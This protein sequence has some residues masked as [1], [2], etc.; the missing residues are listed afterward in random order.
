MSYRSGPAAACALLS[1]FLLP[2][3][4]A[5]AEGSRSLYPAS[6]PSGSTATGARANLDLQPGTRYMNRV[7]RRGFIYAYAR[8]GEYI[9]LGS[10]NTGSES[11][12]RG[13]INVYDPQNFGIPGDETLPASADF[14]CTGGSSA[15]GPHYNGPDL[16]RIRSRA[17]ELAGPNSADGNATVTGG[18]A[19]CAYRAPVDG[20]YG[21]LFTVARTGGGPNGNVNQVRRSTNSVAAWEVVV[22]DSADT[23]E[24][25]EGRVFTYAFLGFTGGNNR[26]VF[27]SLYYVTEDGYRYRQDLRGLDPNGYALYANTFGFLDDNEPLYK[28]LR[29]DSFAVDNLPLGVSAQPAEYPIFFSDIGPGGIGES[30]AETVLAALDIP[31]QPPSPQIS[32]VEFVGTLGGAVTSTGVG[33]AFR[34]NTTD[35]VSYE[36]VISRDGL[37]FDAASPANRVL[38][39]IAYT[40]LHEAVWDGLDNNRQP[41]PASAEPYPYRAYG[42]NGEVHFPIIDAENNGLGTAAVPGGGPTI[43]RL[44]GAD[45]DDA[46]VFFDDRGYVTRSGE[47]IGNLNGT[48]CPGP[49]PAAA[50]PPVSLAGVDS[51]TDYRRWQNGANRNSDCNP[52]AGWGDAKGVN[53]WTYFLTPQFSEVL[54]IREF[55][56]DVATSVTVVDTAEPGD[57]VQGSFSYANNGTASALQVSYS[58]SLQ[59]GLSGVLF[60]NLP[61]GAGA[62]YDPAD[63]TVTFTGFPAQL[64]PGERF[65]QLT[66]RYIAPASGPV[67][68]TTGISTTSQDEF[69][70]NDSATGSTAI[71]AVDVAAAITGVPETASPGAVV[72]GSVLFSNIGTGDA[73]GITYGFTIGSPGNT[74]AGVQFPSLPNGVNAS[75]DPASG[76]VSLTG[77]PDMLVPGDVVSLSF[78]YT[79]PGSDGSTIPVEATIDGSGDAD[80]TN[81]RAAAETVFSFPPDASLAIDARSVCIQD[82]PYVE[83][84]VTAVNFTPTS[85]ATVEF[86][87]SDGSVV[88]TLTDQ[89]LA[90]AR[91]LWPGAATDPGGNGV[92]WPGWTFDGND[93]QPVPSLVRPA[94][95]VRISVNPTAEVS[96]FYPQPAAD[97]N[98]NPPGADLPGGPP[99]PGQPWPPDNGA[100]GNAAPIPTLGLPILGVLSLL[101][102][103]AG[104]GHLRARA[105]D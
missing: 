92:A 3:P 12:Y 83:Y 104:A 18:Y 89:P 9:L 22:R 29:S 57:L 26:P 60:G 38:T 66:F 15:P 71:G 34:F 62:S 55:T 17:A 53:L 14:T 75:F 40:G 70:D 44:N 41:F 76:A 35:T 2:T 95:T 96:I 7:I 65:D 99:G 32:D 48:L 73:S 77:M 81:N 20:V 43:I 90:G 100:I 42:R 79:A 23:L 8:A 21:V 105:P 49:T 64:A 84:D 24:D 52:T 31:L 13:D 4:P 93:W 39:G 10:S 16:G 50:N 54:E 98:T 94:L 33:G 56:V 97:C 1:L 28:T 47:L 74:P 82:A 6:Y 36:I 27:S 37:D 78:A 61:P 67:T 101:T 80:S 91:L 88:Q 51:R 102:L 5:L 103:L 46:T 86:L 59:A 19:P 85:L 25:L 58:L 30:G 87:G 45:P 68:V 72:T 11:D 69:P 63:G